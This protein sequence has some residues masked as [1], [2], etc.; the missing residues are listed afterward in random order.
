MQGFE[1]LTLPLA[2]GAA[3]WVGF[4]WVLKSYEILNRDR[5][6]VIIGQID[7]QAISVEHQ[8]LIF[9]NDWSLL[10]VGLVGYLAA[11]G[12]L[13]WVAPN[14]APPELQLTKIEMLSRVLSFFPF[15]AAAAF[16]IGFVRDF[17]Y[18]RRTIHNRRETPADAQREIDA[19]SLAGR[20]HVLTNRVPR[21][22]PLR[23]SAIR[24]NQNGDSIHSN[25]NPS[26][27]AQAPAAGAASVEKRD[28]GAGT[29]SQR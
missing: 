19:R 20:R 21:G 28:G 1:L 12:L 9:R 10:Y 26:T 22:W 29:P 8:E 27:N 16:G 3:V 14:F 13:F 11:F 24:R 4:G 23:T 7:G 2:F 17:N 25:S 15:F 5:D 18:L 6:R